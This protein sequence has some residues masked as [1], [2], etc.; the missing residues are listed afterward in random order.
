MQHIFPTAGASGGYPHSFHRRF[1]FVTGDDGSAVR[2]ESDQNHVVGVMLLSH[3][4]TDVHHAIVGHV[5]KAGITDVSV[6]FPNDDLG[7]RA[8]VSH[9]SLQ[10]LHHVPVTDVPRSGPALDHR[11]VIPLRVLDD[12]S[13][14]IRIESRFAAIDCRDV[15]VT[16]KLCQ[17]VDHFVFTIFVRPSGGSRVFLSV[18]AIGLEAPKR[19]ACDWQ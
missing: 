17:H 5:G 6:V 1:P 19:L 18:F 14:L 12:Q 10:R 11:P 7:F 15:A 16:T 13:I 3:Q 8:T 9:Q 4:L 2:G